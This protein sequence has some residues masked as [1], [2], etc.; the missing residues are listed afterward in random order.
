MGTAFLIEQNQHRP[1]FMSISYTLS[2]SDLQKTVCACNADWVLNIFLDIC[3]IFTQFF[4]QC[5]SQYATKCCPQ[6][7][8]I[9][10]GKGYQTYIHPHSLNVCVRERKQNLRKRER[11]KKRVKER[12]RERKI[13][14]S[15]MAD[16]P[17]VLYKT[18]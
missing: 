11:L 15:C 5:S 4:C 6:R 12:E 7:N 3:K 18:M 2:V 9:A 10:K 14:R 16:G 13:G 8:G 17:K 1:Y